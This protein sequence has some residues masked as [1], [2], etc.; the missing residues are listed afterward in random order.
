MED[1]EFKFPA[2]ISLNRNQNT[3]IVNYLDSGFLFHILSL[4][5][6]ILQKYLIVF[7]RSDTN[8]QKH[9]FPD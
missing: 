4:I 3:Y 5:S 9:N 6:L 8:F 2:H 1:L 7:W